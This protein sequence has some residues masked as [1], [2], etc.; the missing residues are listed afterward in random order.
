[1]KAI[2]HKMRP[3]LEA[4]P[5]N[6]LHK[7]NSSL[8]LHPIRVTPVFDSYWWFAA[9]RQNVFHKRLEGQPAPWT[10]DPVVAA[11]KFTNAYR[12][13][14][15]AS[16]FLIRNVI[17]RN[18]LPDSPIEVVFRI[19]LFK[20]FNKIET[21]EL[22]E[23]TLGEITYKSYKFDHY[24]RVLSQAMSTGKKIYSAAYIMPPS[25]SVF[26]YP[27]KHQNHLRLLE[28]MVKDDLAKRLS[29]QKTMQ[30][31]FELLKSY[32]SIGNFLAYQFI[33]DINYSEVTD[34]SEMDF[35]VPGP[36][37]LDGL[38]KC[39]TDRAN[40]NEAQL[41]RMMA[42]NQEQEFERLGIKF[43]SLW[44]RR[45]QLIDCQNLFCEIDKYARVAH[46]EVA[47]I[48]G[49]TR[50][51][52]KFSPTGPL[53]KPWYPPKWGINSKIE[54]DLLSPALPLDAA[55]STPPAQSKLNLGI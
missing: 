21:W 53:Y 19:L 5:A 32:P 8:H 55:P 46:P 30:G 6:P 51:K 25:S 45:L 34:F 40:L 24:D 27:A 35:V 17:Y 11:N 37:A 49:R 7:S 50:I 14:D 1:M 52:Q 31:A 16:Q 42:E 41:I 39:F 38:K 29:R 2:P 20:F 23:H 47:G 9:E 26:G 43:Q 4:V 18:D 3:L 36:G 44:G 28:R 22:L 48:S 54:T 33:T 10:S 15:R 13:S 12:A